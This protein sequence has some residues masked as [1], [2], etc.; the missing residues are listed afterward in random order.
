MANRDTITAMIAE[1]FE[2][3]SREQAF[4][5]IAFVNVLF[6]RAAKLMHRLQIRLDHKRR[7]TVNSMVEKRAKKLNKSGVN[8]QRR[9]TS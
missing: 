3:R 9:G 5:R 7:R 4:D 6:E 8:G 1:E 2:W